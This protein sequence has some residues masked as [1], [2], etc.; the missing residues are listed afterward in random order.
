ML[1][2]TT[3][4]GRLELPICSPNHLRILGHMA[5]KSGA[6]RYG[7]TGGAMTTSITGVLT[8][9][10]SKIANTATETKSA[11]NLKDWALLHHLLRGDTEEAQAADRPAWGLPARGGYSG[12][13][14]AGQAAAKVYLKHLRVSPVCRA[15]GGSLQNIAMDM[16]SG[17]STDLGTTG[18]ESLRGQAVGFFYE[19]NR[20]LALGIRML[21]SLDAQSFESL[22]GEID[23]GLA[24]TKADDEAELTAGRSRVAREAWQRRKAAAAQEAA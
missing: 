3:R 10:K 20:A 13:C 1:A 18:G 21:E 2:A 17:R 23:E 9:A 19:I 12:G 6:A 14:M 5:S 22:V 24:R 15:F 16:L 7:N 11:D 4:R 8:M